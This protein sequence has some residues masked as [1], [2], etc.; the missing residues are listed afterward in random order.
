MADA[1]LSIMK[2]NIVL[3]VS[4]QHR[5]DWMGCAGHPFLKTPHLDQLAQGGVRFADAY[6]NS[7]LCVPSRMSMMTGRYPH[8]TGVHTNQ[9]CLS[10]DIPTFAHAL[11][12][13][14]YDTVLCGRMHFIGPDQRHGYQKR[15]VGDIT[16]CYPG[17]PETPYGQLKGT[18]MQ[19]M[20]CIE[21]AGP[22]DSPVLRYDEAVVKGFEE[23]LRDRESLADGKPLFMTV[24]LY[25]PHSPFVCPP[26]LFHETWAAMEM[27]DSPIPRDRESFHPWVDNW[28]SKLKL[29]GM[30]EEQW[31]VARAS[32]GGL[33]GQLDRL[34]GRIVAASRSLPGDTVIVY[35]SDHG[36]MAGD[37]GMFWKKNFFEGAVNVPM[38]WCPLVQTS[39]TL[40]WAKRRT[41]HTPVSLIDL[42][43]TLARIGDAPELPNVNGNDL[44]PFLMEQGK[45]DGPFWSNRPVFSELIID[46]SPNRMVR[47]GRYKLIYYHDY[48]ETLLFDLENDPHEQHNLSGH[49]EHANLRGS[50]LR[51]L[52]DNWDPML[53]KQSAQTKADDL[54]YWEQWGRTVG[55]GPL[56]LWDCEHLREVFL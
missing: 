36:E 24:G 46:G 42:A 7:P 34:V 17:A 1:S 14:G 50:L 8:V 16:A 37:R 29:E 22:G 23:Y 12:M 44:T 32:Y 51:V 49:E 38:I 15:L 30:T 53:I 33:V 10:S 9:N 35:V 5:G 39:G 18:A 3:I 55:M 20:K 52:M 4:D 26:D 27:K 13:A 6:C 40:S 47:Q 21:L 2:P 45:P 41:V 43:P 25:G 11:S 48:E 54:K 19:G 28:F 56:D 31:K